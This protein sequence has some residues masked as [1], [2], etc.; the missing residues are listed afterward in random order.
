MIASPIGTAST[1]APTRT[2]SGRASR[3]GFP[4]PRGGFPAPR[5]GTAGG[6]AGPPSAGNITVPPGGP[7]LGLATTGG[8]AGAGRGGRPGGSGDESGGAGRRRGGGAAARSSRFV[9]GT[10]R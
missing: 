3:G 10:P 7:E 4:P 5:A 1:Q 6:T 2:V 8:A 9:T